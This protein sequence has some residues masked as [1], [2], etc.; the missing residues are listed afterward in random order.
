MISSIEKK[1]LSP[2]EL[3]I[4]KMTIQ[5]YTRGQIAG[6]MNLSAETVKTYRKRALVKLKAVCIEHAILRAHQSDVVDLDSISDV[7]CPPMGD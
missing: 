3:E 7:F 1:D 2:R 4:L 6:V 5:G